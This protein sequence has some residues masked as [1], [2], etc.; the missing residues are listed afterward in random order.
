MEILKKEKKYQ[1]TFSEPEL[2]TIYCILMGMEPI[3][4]PEDLMKILM[5]I[6]KTLEWYDI[7]I[8]EEETK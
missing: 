7:Y 5:H 8:H 6:R 4:S 2:K 3:Y 1:I